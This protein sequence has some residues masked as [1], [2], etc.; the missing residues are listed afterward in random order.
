VTGREYHKVRGLAGH[1][2]AR[3]KEW[4]EDRDRE[5]NQNSKNLSDGK[6]IAYGKAAEDVEKLFEELNS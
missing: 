5:T 1:L 4:A 3:S 6:S 2:R